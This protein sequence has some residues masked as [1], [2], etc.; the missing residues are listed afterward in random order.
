MGLH[1]HASGASGFMARRPA[2]TLIS[3]SGNLDFLAKSFID[4]GREYTH[5]CSRRSLGVTTTIQGVP[6]ATMDAYASR[7]SDRM[8]GCTAGAP[9]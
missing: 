4:L 7:A 9:V 2:P 3:N 1:L 6:G 5:E 8:L